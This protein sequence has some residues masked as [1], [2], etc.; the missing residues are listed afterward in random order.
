M[1]LAG[2]EIACNL[3]DDTVTP[4]AAVIAEVQRLATAAGL[5]MGAA[6]YVLGAT[7]EELLRHEQ[8]EQQRS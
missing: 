1:T 3:L 2:T 5:P 6:A 8:L 7:R 4:A